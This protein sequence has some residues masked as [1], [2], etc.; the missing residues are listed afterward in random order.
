MANSITRTG[1]TTASELKKLVAE[2]RPLIEQSL[3]L[4]EQFSALREAATEKGIDW[5]QV[6]AL[7]KAQIQDERDGEGKRVGRILEK[8]DFASAYA[9]MLGFG[10]MN[11]NNFSSPPAV[12]LP[13]VDTSNRPFGLPPDTDRLRM[14]DDAYPELPDKLR[15]KQPATAT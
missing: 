7:L 6:K 3:D 14:P 5:S 10:K 8:A 13:K 1:T 9:D 15:R 12:E 4:S 2:S 11:E